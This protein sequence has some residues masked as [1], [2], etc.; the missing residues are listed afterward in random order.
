MLEVIPKYI[1]SPNTSLY[2]QAFQSQA[3]TPNLDIWTLTATGL[4]ASTLIP[5]DSD[6]K[7][8]LI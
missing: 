1:Q 4:P 3:K 8:L 6:P 2:L 7:D 5:P